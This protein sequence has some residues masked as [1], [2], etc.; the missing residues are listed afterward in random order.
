M[1]TFY[2]INVG[3]HLPNGLVICEK[4]FSIAE[5]CSCWELVI[6]AEYQRQCCWT[7]S[8]N[9]F[10][11]FSFS[12]SQLPATKA[13]SYSLLH[14]PRFSSPVFS[15]LFPV[16]KTKTNSLSWCF[17]PKSVPSKRIKHDMPG[18]TKM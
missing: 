1:P 8:H 5:Y 7:K 18:D 10:D 2:V 17:S 13:R 16:K 14:H 11:Q 15:S 3:F 4:Y 9:C 6:R 12:E